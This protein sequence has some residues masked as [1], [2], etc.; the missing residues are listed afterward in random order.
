MVVFVQTMN[1]LMNRRNCLLEST[2]NRGLGNQYLATMGKIPI[3]SWDRYVGAY[4]GG[5]K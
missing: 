2:L 1:L 5:V 3:Q 4:E